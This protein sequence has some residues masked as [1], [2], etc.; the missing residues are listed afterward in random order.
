[1]KTQIKRY[2]I[3][4]A[5]MLLWLGTGPVVAQNYYTPGTTIRG[6]GFTYI[7]ED[8]PGND[9][10]FGG[11]GGVRVRNANNTLTYRPPLRNGQPILLVDDTPLIVGGGVDYRMV[12]NIASSVM[13][14]R[15]RENAMSETLVIEIR[16]DPQTGRIREI[17]FVMDPYKNGFIRVAPEKLFQLETALKQQAV[18]ELT[19]VGKTQ[20]FVNS[21]MLL[22]G[23]DIGYTY[24]F[25]TGVW[26][27]PVFPVPTGIDFVF[28]NESSRDMADLYVGLTGSIGGAYTQFI[29]SD[30][31]TVA[32][33]TS[34]GLPYY[35]GSNISATP[36]VAITD[37]TLELG[38]SLYNS[39]NYFEDLMVTAWVDGA[40]Q[41]NYASWN[42][43]NGSLLLP[44]TYSQA[45]V[46]RSGRLMLT[47][48]ISD[49]Y[50]GWSAPAPTKLPV[51][52][53]PVNR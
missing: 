9:P 44:L 50:Q 41:A 30:P 25:S 4:I 27:E 42:V 22:R 46:P 14:A 33:G 11:F 13:T 38:G 26:R 6:N 39:S 31:G 16:I 43:D 28:I 47:V 34:T 7:C 40:G 45:T 53:L 19:A 10:R 21:F 3:L 51:D 52:S 29:H 48:K 17:E 23:R 18:Y 37:L 24:D 5:M 1:M 15:D 20:N 35:P 49:Y 32:P 8:D 36:G 2:R 12:C